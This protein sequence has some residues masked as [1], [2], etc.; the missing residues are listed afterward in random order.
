MAS[1]VEA[2]RCREKLL[3]RDYETLRLKAQ[4]AG[5]DLSPAARQQANQGAGSNA[6]QQAAP[7]TGTS[8]LQQAASVLDGAGVAPPQHLALTPLDGDHPLWLYV[9]GS[10]VRADCSSA[11]LCVACIS[12]IWHTPTCKRWAW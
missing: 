8:P 5:I 9:N 6:A 7:Q 1:Q 12:N 4:Q 3:L 2:Y 11:G 10:R